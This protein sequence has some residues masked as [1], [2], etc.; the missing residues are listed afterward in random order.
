MVCKKNLIDF[1]KGKSSE[2]R[3]SRPRFA[4]E[5]PSDFGKMENKDVFSRRERRLFPDFLS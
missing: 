3:G 4:Q 1:L 5:P 2:F